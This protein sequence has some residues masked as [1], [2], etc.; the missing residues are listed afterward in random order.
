MDNQYI[1]EIISLINN[2]NLKLIKP[3]VRSLV[4]NNEGINC[5]EGIV[6]DNLLP[7]TENQF[8]CS[9]NVINMI[10]FSLYDEWVVEKF[11]FSEGDSFSSHCDALPQNTNLEIIQKNCYRVLKIIR[12]GIIHN[13]SGIKLCQNDYDINYKNN[14]DK[15]FSCN[16]SQIGL[17]LLYSIIVMFATGDCG[18][19]TEG[20]FEY[21]V[22][23]LY[24]QLL[25]EIN[26]IKDE[27]DED[28]F[29]VT[30]K[31]TFY[32]TVRYEVSNCLVQSETDYL[33]V[34][35]F[36]DYPEMNQGHDYKIS[37]NGATYLIPGEIIGVTKDDNYKANI[38]LLTK[39]WVL[40]F[41]K[42]E[43]LENV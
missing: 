12:N 3:K 37:Y 41:T 6:T 8:L 24:A 30:T 29:P 38:N 22:S 23:T 4:I 21:V 19:P 42:E 31:N 7:H 28:L 17:R 1:S 25:G 13:L 15:T 40:R 9:F 43:I 18:I 34:K 10:L 39:E 20:H 26:N 11:N 14:R 5:S 2:S 35:C 36:Q 27:F 33:I 16:I 32:Y